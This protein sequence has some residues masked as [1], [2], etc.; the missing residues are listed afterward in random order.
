MNNVHGTS[1]FYKKWNVCFLLLW[2]L[3]G[4][5]TV[6]AEMEDMVLIPAGPFLMGSDQGTDREQPVHEQLE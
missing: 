5:S 3:M 6:Q 2:F 4:M 1:R